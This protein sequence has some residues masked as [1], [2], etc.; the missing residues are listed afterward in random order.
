MY[1]NPSGQ[2]GSNGPISYLLKEASSSSGTNTA[3][4]YYIY[5]FFGYHQHIADIGIIAF[6][7]ACLKLKLKHYLVVVSVRFGTNLIL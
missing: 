4:I 6:D 1:T 7:V 3:V 5:A 2:R